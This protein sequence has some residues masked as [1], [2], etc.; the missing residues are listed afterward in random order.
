[1]NYNT[2]EDSQTVFTESVYFY[3]LSG[4]ATFYVVNKCPLYTK[5]KELSAHCERTTT[6]GEIIDRGRATCGHMHKNCV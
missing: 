4:E 5:D 6:S 1:M 2:F 3:L